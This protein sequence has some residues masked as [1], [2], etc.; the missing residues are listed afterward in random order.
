[1]LYL[2]ELQFKEMIH[3]YDNWYQLNDNGIWGKQ[4]PGNYGT[5]AFARLCLCTSKARL[6]PD[7]DTVCICN[8]QSA[9]KLKLSAHDAETQNNIID[10]LTPYLIEL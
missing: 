6:L 5:A 9:Y 1:M 4:I 10:V 2:L 7:N 8:Y 3:I